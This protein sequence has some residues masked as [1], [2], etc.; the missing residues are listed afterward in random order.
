MENKDKQPL[1]HEE[2][3]AFVED[4]RAGKF[5][6][7]DISFREILQCTIS[8]EDVIFLENNNIQ[9]VGTIL[10]GIP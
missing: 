10:Y 2:I 6:D 5:S 1:N 8:R 9:D 4:T 7:T 3:V